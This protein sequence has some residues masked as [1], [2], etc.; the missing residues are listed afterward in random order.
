MIDEE[1]T[2]EFPAV[3]KRVFVH[4]E[5]YLLDGT[6]IDTS[7]EQIARDNGIFNSNNP[8][9]PFDFVLGNSGIIDGFSLGVGLLKVGG[10]GTFLIPSV[11]AYQD[12][13]IASVPPHANLIFRV[14]LEEILN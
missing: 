6:F 3:G 1:G 11:L 4:Y 13:Q 5:T 12:Q 8:Y 14:T 10:S 9:L 2:G 7:K